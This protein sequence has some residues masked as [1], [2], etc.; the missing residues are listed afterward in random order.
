MQ[1]C[2]EDRAGNLFCLRQSD[3]RY[4]PMLLREKVKL[5][6]LFFNDRVRYASLNLTSL[7]RFG[8]LEFRGMRGAD[9]DFENVVTWLAII[10]SLV[11]NAIDKFETPAD[12][13]RAISGEGV[14][15]LLQKL[16][17]SDEIYRQLVSVPNYRRLVIESV[18]ATQIWVMPVK[19][20]YII[21]KEEIPKTPTTLEHEE[22]LLQ[23]IKPEDIVPYD[24]SSNYTTQWRQQALNAMEF[25]DT[26]DVPAEP[27][28]LDDE[29]EEEDTDDDF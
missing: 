4:L 13:I 20:E 26:L 2:G 14:D 18:R 5:C 6:D 7:N 24:N 27:V 19:W 23:K 17:P 29:E 15:I 8:T 12:I 16:F 28:E 3:A 11:T 1:W 25:L 9:P 10:N 21:G 22:P